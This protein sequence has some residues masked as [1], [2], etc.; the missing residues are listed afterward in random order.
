MDLFAINRRQY[1]KTFVVYAVISGISLFVC[2]IFINRVGFFI[3]S[4]FVVNLFSSVLSI[5]TIIV[6]II[7][8]ERHQHLLHTL[9]LNSSFDERLQ[10]YKI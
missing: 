4:S 8:T 7:L 6:S 9:Q 2:Y 3:G 10:K 1:Q 5:I